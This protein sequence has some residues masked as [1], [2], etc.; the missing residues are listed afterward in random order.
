MEKNSYHWYTLKCFLSTL[1]WKGAFMGKFFKKLGDSRLGAYTIA[2]CTAV[3]LYMILSRFSGIGSFFGRLVYYLSPFFWGLII[4]YILLP[5][6]DFL[7]DRCFK[8]FKNRRLARNLSILI[9]VLFMLA[10]ISFLISVIVPQLLSSCQLLI[11]NLE[12]YFNTFMHSAEGFASRFDMLDLDVTKLLGN[13]NDILQKAINFVLVNSRNL[14]S[15]S[16]KIGNTIFNAVIVLAIAIYVMA[17]KA[18]LIAGAKRL[19]MALFKKE[20]YDNIGYILGHSHRILVRYIG[21][22][23][24]DGLLIGVANFLFMTVTGMPY[25]LLISVVVG[26]TNLVPTFGPCFGGACAFIILLIIRPIQAFWFLLWIIVLQQID[27][28]VIKPLLFGETVGLPSLWV[29][30]SIVVAGRMFGIAGMLLAVPVA[31]ILWLIIEEG[32]HAKLVRKGIEEVNGKEGQLFP[33]E[34]PEEK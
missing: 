7:A 24:V 11:N 26:V 17:D 10:A 28:N 27:G 5:M 9:T 32:L 14:I 16:V 21:S 15:A 19:G 25:P 22:D 3:I 18:R 6:T 31:A 8:G 33:F 13:W 4:A 30:V 1:F 20:T 34:D 2:S 29:L 23:L 12:G